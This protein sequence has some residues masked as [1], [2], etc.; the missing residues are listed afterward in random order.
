MRLV[1]SC[2]SFI[3]LIIR[4]KETKPTTIR[5]K[6]TWWRERFVKGS[7]MLHSIISMEREPKEWGTNGQL[8]YNLGKPELV[9]NKL[10]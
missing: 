3:Q 10:S 5:S 4:P 2:V 7:F 6:P 9:Y 1:I 8:I